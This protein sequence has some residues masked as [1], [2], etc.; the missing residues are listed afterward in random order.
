MSQIKDTPDYG[1]PANVLAAV[2]LMQ[3]PERI[4]ASNRALVDSLM[5]GRRPYTDQEVAEHQIQINVNWGEGS[6]I[7]QDANRQVNNALLHKGNFVTCTLNSGKVEKRDDRSAVF[8]RNINSVLKRGKS[9]KKYLFLLKNRNCSLVL[10]G[11]GALMWPN[12]YDWMPRF[13]A[14]EDLLIPTGTL[15]DFTNMTNFAVNLY[16][17]PYELMTMT[18]GNMDIAKKAGWN[19]EAV[20]KILSTYGKL[21]QNNDQ[22]NWWD[23]PEEMVNVWKQ[24][25]VVCNSDSVPK[26]HLVA[27]YYRSPEGG[28]ENKEK[29][30]RKIC[31][32]EIAAAQGVNKLEINDEFIFDSGKTVFAD[33]IDRILAIQ[34]GDCN[35]VPP[36]T[37][38][39]TR[40]LGETL[41]AVVECMNRLRCQW[42]QHV[43][44][45]LLMLIRVQNPTDQDRPKVFNLKPYGVIE[46]GVSIIP[47]NERHQVDPRIVEMAMSENRQLLSENSASFVQDIDNGTGKEQTLGEAQIRLQTANKMVSGMLDMM[48]TLETFQLEEIVRRFLMPNPKDPDV[49]KFR[50]RCKIDGIPDDLMKPEFWTVEA[51]RVMGGGDQ[52]LAQQEASMLLVN[53]Q[54]YDTTSQRAILRKWTTTMTRNPAMG[55]MLVPQ[56]ENT[57]TAGSMAADQLFGSLMAGTQ[58]GVVEGIEQRDYVGKM[59]DNMNSV[60]ERIEGTDQVGTQQDVIG[61]N[62]VAADIGQHLELMAQNPENKEFVTAVGKELGKQ[63]NLVKA[64]Q[65]RQSEKSNETQPDPEAIAKA[66]ATE[67]QAQQKQQMSEAAFIQKIEQKEKEFQQKMAHDQQMFAME[68]QQARTQAMA[69]LREQSE[70]A[71]SEI[72]SRRVSNASQSQNPKEE[73]A[74]ATTSPTAPSQPIVINVDVQASKP[75]KMKIERDSDGLITGATPVDQDKTDAPN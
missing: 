57:T 23:R 50:E 8:T 67:A 36:Q 6:K 47:Q 13:V 5:N 21:N 32:K 44:E 31:L 60:I 35:L 73:P 14:L 53:S 69:D 43:F 37:Y 20:K 75:G 27:F 18:M 12:N 64:Y 2:E 9:G 59:M 15:Q 30:Y 39:S 72:E 61:L 48:Y 17:T 70:K 7:L 46:D 68:M 22:Y 24:N 41:Y 25:Q 4:R 51:D 45:D 65:Q 3:T 28:T 42:M 54:R 40:G 52:A 16:L 33:D 29:W 55:E 58:V 1:S 63:M 10:H 74:T 26:V 34:Y 11:I 62:M 66:Q 56:K 38:H 49:V 19:T 71:S